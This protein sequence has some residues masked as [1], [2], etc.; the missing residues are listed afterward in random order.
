MIRILGIAPYP[1]LKYR[2][3]EL[4]LNFPEVE[5]V[6]YIGDL[7]DG[8]KIAQKYSDNFDLILSRGGT[9]KLIRQ[10][11]NLP[12]IDIEIS[13]LDIL[14]LVKMV[15]IYQQKYAFIGFSN[16]TKQITTLSEILDKPLDIITID[17]QAALPKLLTHLR[18]NDY[19]LVIG[20]N[21][22]AMSAHDMQLNS[23]LIE[24]GEESLIDSIQRAI[25]LGHQLQ[26]EQS[27]LEALIKAHN[28]L[29]TSY[30][31][32][33]HSFHLLNKQVVG[34]QKN[35]SSTLS[36]YLAHRQLTTDEIVVDH[37]LYEKN[38][39]YNLTLSTDTE[40]IYIFVQDITD[41]M[42]KQD[43]IYDLSSIDNIQKNSATLIGESKAQIE[44]A[45]TLNKTILITGET[46]TGKEKA[47]L[48]LA[49]RSN[50]KKKWLINLKHLSSSSWNQLFISPHSQLLDS[51][52]AFFFQGIEELSTTQLDYLIIFI[53][54]LTS[55]RSQWTL[56]CNP[57]TEQ[58]LTNIKRLK[59]A[60]LPYMITL[61]PLRKRQDELGSIIGLYVYAFNMETT[62]Q[63]I[64]FEPE[65]MHLMT[66]FS[67]PGNLSQLKYVVHQL[68]LNNK[69]AF[70]STKSVKKALIEETNLSLTNGQLTDIT[71]EWVG[72]SLT[73]IE[74]VI[75]RIMLNKNKGNKTKTAQQLGIS[76]STLWRLLKIDN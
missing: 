51:D 61:K 70:I 9:A 54:T 23:I 12:V 26:R 17:N 72:Q 43:F 52:T 62:K 40:C 27:K 29:N 10:A 11:I 16:I 60:L 68:V 71:N 67:W 30:Y 55:V 46:G 19:S 28:T 20:D 37:L 24:S 38:N 8:V 5:L 32:F 35:I 49:T 56:S 64:G 45:A 34:K 48:I 25:M 7:E 4:A 31:I 76:R 69:T 53:Q 73:Q 33:D 66:K 59:N 13:F 22:T 50:H 58:G 39:Y 2:L 21:I 3:N 41:K 74:L 14:R 36:R 63:I 18:E 75:I 1:N 6:T 57:Q 44:T 42:K 15:D 65:A 47:L